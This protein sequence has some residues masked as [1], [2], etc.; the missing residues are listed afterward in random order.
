MK[1]YVYLFRRPEILQLSHKFH[2]IYLR[3]S[4]DPKRKLIL[5]RFVSYTTRAYFLIRNLYI[6][7]AALIG[8][9]PLI[10]GI[11]LERRILPFGLFLP[12]I[13]HKSSPGYEIN[14]AYLIWTITLCIPGLAASE[15]YFVMLVILGIGHLTMMIGML[16][17]LNGV[18]KLKNSTRGVYQ[19]EMEVERRIKDIILEHQDHYK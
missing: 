12:F 13:D 11:L 15:A 9:C 10:A 19:L 14:Y 3:S 16:D 4:G 2:A 7:V 8:F 18:L 6:F 5:D 1:I 17:E